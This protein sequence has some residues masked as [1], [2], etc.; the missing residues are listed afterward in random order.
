ME[1]DIRTRCLH[2]DE[3]RQEAAR[4]YGAVSYPI[5]QSATFAH[6]AVGVGT[7]YD[8]GRLANPTRTQLT[9]TVAALECGSGALAF[10]SGMAA[11]AALM[12]LFA[13]GDH[14]IID[15]DLYGG[16]VRLF[17]DIGSKNGITFTSLD[18]SREDVRPCIGD[19]T[20]AIFLETPTNPMMRVADIRALG[21]VAK[22]HGILLIVDNTFLSPYFQNPLT[23]GADIVV[24]S[25]TKYLGGH[26]DT[27]AGFLVAK[28]K[29][30][31]QE[32]SSIET[33]TGAVLA[34][35]DSWLILRGIKT[36]AVRMEAAQKNAFALVA[37]LLAQPKVRRV[38][39]PG[40]ATHPGHAL[41]KRQSRGYGAMITFEVESKECALSVLKRVRLIRFAESLGGTESLLTYPLTQTHADVPKDELDKRG[42]TDRILRLSV[43]IEDAGDLIRDLEQAFAG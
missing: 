18:L 34:P 24:H 6:E 3:E 25:G 22:E 33:T 23:L 41:M 31:L 37:W 30:L 29:Q 9:R 40:L 17:A 19:A 8:Y 26:N 27:L 13:P 5:Y 16:S 15:E 32:L 2:T 43:G 10:S 4:N 7:G 35:M 12:E 21:R 14:L 20:K 28:D 36:L 42:I 38:F 1:L 39:Y 11:I